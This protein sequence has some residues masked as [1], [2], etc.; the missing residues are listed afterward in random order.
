VFFI[1]M[2]YI[3]GWDLSSWLK[4][5]GRLPVEIAVVVLQ[6][7]AAGLQH[8]HERSIIHRDVKPGNVMLTSN[9]EVK[10]LDFGLARDMDAEG[11]STPG[12]LMGTYAYMSP[13]Q[14]DGEEAT[15]SFD[16][17]ALGVVAYQLLSNKIPFEGTI[18][19]VCMKIKNEEPAP[20][21]K[22]CPEAPRD[23]VKLVQRMM[24]KKP[25]QRPR[26]MREVEE[27]L[28]EIAGKIGLKASE[29]LL[30]R[31]VDDPE[32]AV[33][34]IA[35]RRA[36]RKWRPW[37]YGAAAAAA[38]IV[39]GVL[40]AQLL[41]RRGPAQQPVAA[42]PPADSALADTA[43]AALPVAAPPE[44][45][46]VAAAPA[47]DT[48]LVAAARA[49]SLAAAAAVP[50][51]PSAAAA[52]GVTATTPGG[53]LAAPTGEVSSAWS[54]DSIVVDI[55][56]APPCEIYLDDVLVASAATHWTKRVIRKQWTVRVDAGDYGTREQ[57]KKPRSQ[58]TMIAFKLDLTVGEGGVYVRGPRNGLDI[59]IDGEYRRAATPSPVRPLKVGPCLVEV[60][61][62]KTGQVV[63]SK[64]I[65]VKEGSNNLVVDFTAGR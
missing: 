35:R 56:A 22:L 8:A 29:D 19:T 49:E 45:V 14:V 24:A 28:R 40:V 44:T 51:A 2:E 26:D 54:A 32:A 57:K 38:V 12:T 48:A 58:D 1:E 47:R 36:R 25:S 31:Y 55:T 4:A 42:A 13:E 30:P 33:Q 39:L 21:D 9:G 43:V 5:H 11:R 52:G 17:Y 10:V 18:A 41:M 3:D 65:V 60:R 64:Q 62:R 6:H 61:D 16:V 59:W 23:L 34:L 50:G 7:F 20:L 15:T 46:A 27:A 37:A 53:T 63:A